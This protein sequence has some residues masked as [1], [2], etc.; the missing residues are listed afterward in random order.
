MGYTIK[1][2]GNSARA[3]SIINML[4]TFEKE[5]EDIQIFEDHSTYASDELSPELLQ[6]LDRRMEYMEK[7]PE[8]GKTWDEIKK[9]Q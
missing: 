1:I 6:E 4:K 2:S 5:F 8:A 3:K 9:N 7:H